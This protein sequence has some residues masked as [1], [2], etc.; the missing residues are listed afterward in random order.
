MSETKQDVSHEELLNKTGFTF[1]AKNMVALKEKA[2]HLKGVKRRLMIAYEFHRFVRQE[3][4]DAF[5]NKLKAKTIKGKEPIN[6][7]WQTL[8]F[9]PIANYAGIPPID[10]LQKVEEAVERKIFD[11][12]EVAFIRDVKD[13]I[14]FGRI[15]DCSDRFFVAQWDDDVKISDLLKEN[16]G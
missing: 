9:M 12:F 13:P 15:T 6:A 3:Q 7:T 16:E 14:V 1:A 11:C 8:E 5:N 4:V 10:V 2:Q